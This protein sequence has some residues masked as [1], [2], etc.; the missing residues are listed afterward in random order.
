MP[1]RSEP[2]SVVYRDPAT[3]DP[4][5]GFK[6]FWRHDRCGQEGYILCD[7]PDFEDADVLLRKA[8][9][10]L[11]AEHECGVSAGRNTHWQFEV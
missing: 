5:Y 1:E 6:T 10:Q 9:D 11:M 4:D 8:A 7:A 3:D 2:I